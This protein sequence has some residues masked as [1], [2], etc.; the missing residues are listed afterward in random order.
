MVK[1]RAIKSIFSEAFRGL[2]R[3][4]EVEPSPF[5]EYPSRQPDRVFHK[6][7]Q[8]HLK[9]H[10]GS[11]QR[12]FSIRGKSVLTTSQGDVSGLSSSPRT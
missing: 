9:S 11:N 3:E 7:I 8:K 5:P 1:E 2:V 4:R 12:P 10:L 6:D